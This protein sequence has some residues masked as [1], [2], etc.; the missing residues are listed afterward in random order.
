MTGATAP[1]QIRHRSRRLIGRGADN[2]A[3]NRIRRRRVR[4]VREEGRGVSSQYGREGGGGAPCLARRAPSAF[5]EGEGSGGRGCKGGARGAQALLH[6]AHNPGAA[7]AGR[8]PRPRRGSG[9]RQGP[10]APARSAL[11]SQ[12]TCEQSTPTRLTR[13]PGRSQRSSR[14]AQSGPA[15]H[16][17]PTGS[18]AE[19]MP[20]T[21]TCERDAACPISTG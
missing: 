5:Q 3:L 12:G 4:L 19:P 8:V 18:A 16:R 13:A 9:C 17:A 14:R 2:S 10:E 6:P 11:Q 20:S 7:R 21:C 15:A 1:R